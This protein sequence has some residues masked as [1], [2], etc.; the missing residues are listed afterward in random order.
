MVNTRSFPKPDGK[1][2]VRPPEAVEDGLLTILKSN[3]SG[4]YLHVDELDEARAAGNGD[5]TAM[6]EIDEPRFST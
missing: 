1:P 6:K 3:L 4:R 5:E 2:G